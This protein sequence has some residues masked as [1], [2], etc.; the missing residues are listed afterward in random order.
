VGRTK[1][2]IDHRRCGDG[3]GVDP[4]ECGLC[5]RACAPAVFV[6]HQT[7]G[8]AEPDPL[9]P[10]AWRVTPMWASLCT[11]CGECTS[12][13][14]QKAIELS[15]VGFWHTRKLPGAGPGDG[16]AAANGNTGS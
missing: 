6:L 1:I 3:T 9:D 13:C 8:A 16:P 15:A 10:K 5:L 11:R 2:T 14:P 4:R 7:L 12:A